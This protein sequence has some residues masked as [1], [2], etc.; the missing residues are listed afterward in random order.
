M[1]STPFLCRS[2]WPRVL[3]HRSTAA[4]LLRLWVRIPPE[5]WMFVCC[6]C[7][8]L[9]GRGLC[10]GLIIRSEDSYRLW[11]V[12]VCDQVTSSWI[13][14]SWECCVCCQVEV[15]ATEWS[16]VQRSPTDCGASLCM[17]KELRTRRGYNPVRGLPNTNSQRVVAPVGTM[18][19]RLIHKMGVPW[20]C[21]WSPQLSSFLCD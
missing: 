21:S 1:L 12:A 10:D 8:V 2:Q 13:Y 6:K 9:S 18:P 19:D 7:C 15:S 14:V 5:A 16:L 11:R 3:R 17:I 4:R 20:S